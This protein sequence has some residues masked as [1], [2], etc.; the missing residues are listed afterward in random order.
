MKRQ[1]AKDE[2]FRGNGRKIALR[3]LQRLKNRHGV[4]TCRYSDDNG[5]DC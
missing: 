3:L 4:G 2:S 5:C 1:T